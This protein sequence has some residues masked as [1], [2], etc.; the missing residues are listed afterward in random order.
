MSD[1]QDEAD[2]NAP[3]PPLFQEDFGVNGGILAPTS[4][5][6]LQ[7]WIAKEIAFWSWAPN[8]SVG[9]HR[10]SFDLAWRNLS[11]VQPPLNQGAQFSAQGDLEATK[12]A[13]LQIASILRSVYVTQRLPHSS[14]PW[15]HRIEELRANPVIAHAYLYALMGDAPGQNT[16]FGPATQEA[17]H[18]FLLGLTERYG[19][20]NSLDPAVA[21]QRTAL[22]ELR[23]KASK[24]LEEKKQTI[25]GL[26]RNYSSVAEEISTQQAAQQG[27]FNELLTEIKDAHE[28]ALKEHEEKLESVRKSFKE[29]MALRAPVDYWRQKAEKHA[30]KSLV[31]ARWM[32][33]GMV[34]LALAFLAL[35]A[36]VFSSLNS[37]KPD[38]W[39]IAAPILVGVV[40]V[41]AVRLIVRMYLSQAHLATDAEERV[42]MV[43]TYLSLLEEG[44]MPETGD[45]Q[46]V[47]TPLFRPA[48]DGMVK[49]DGIPHPVLEML[50]KLNPRG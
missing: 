6:E 11:N 5:A 4:I 15:A 25:E 26:E 46:L 41:W 24:L 34:A 20:V 8:V 1:A 35:T 39:K 3:P 30:R 14:T 19:I 37:G 28:T 29:A 18:G 42:T 10:N 38:T 47:L 22:D 27:D 32:F 36:L 9:P 16:A 43:Q 44:K 12:R 45:R 23:E 13:A 48:T 33:G 7:Q 21:T 17:W 2:L 40:A 49:E 50:T 31:L